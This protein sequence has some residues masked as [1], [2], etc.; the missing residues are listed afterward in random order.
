MKLF[1]LPVFGPFFDKEFSLFYL[2]RFSIIVYDLNK[3][4]SAEASE[5]DSLTSHLRS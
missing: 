5:R 3:S 2:F 4:A 1:K